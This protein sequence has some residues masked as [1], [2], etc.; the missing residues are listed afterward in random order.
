MKKNKTRSPP[1][2]SFK[3]LYSLPYS[4]LQGRPAFMV[5]NLRLKKNSLC[6]V[7]KHHI[8][9]NYETNYDNKILINIHAEQIAGRLA[10]AKLHFR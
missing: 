3:C 10:V 2:D 9:I 8:F 7:D 1:N 4:F 6:F 5:E